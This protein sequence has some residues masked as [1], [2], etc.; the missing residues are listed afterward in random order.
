MIANRETLEASPRP[1]RYSPGERDLQIY[2]AVRVDARRQADVAAEFG[3][4]QGRIS[5]IIRRVNR[6]RAS[7]GSAGELERRDQ[8]TV[9]RWLD[10]QRIEKL[11]EHTMEHYRRSCQPR[12]R[13][14][15]VKNQ[16]GES[17]TET[18][19]HGPGNLQCLKFA[20]HLLELRFGFDQQTP[21]SEKALE[22][23]DRDTFFRRLADMRASAE[24][25]GDVPAG[26]GNGN[27]PA[28][29]AYRMLQE[30]IGYGAAR[31]AFAPEPPDDDWQDDEPAEP[32]ASPP[33]AAN[34][35]EIINVISAAAP[36]EEPAAAAEEVV[37]TACPAKTSDE[38]TAQPAIEVEP[39]P[40]A[41][42]SQVFVGSACRAEPEMPRDVDALVAD[43]DCPDEGHSWPVPTSGPPF[44]AG[45]EAQCA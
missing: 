15:I 14:R 18:I 20:G 1:S 24:E 12:W 6:W 39:S 3:I 35:P 31:G 37:L 13:E 7:R 26:E 29:V 4:T 10:D 16:H 33:A 34:A 36:A 19:D 43:I 5:Q 38:P 23:A 22:E 28:D 32:A 44:M 21:P 27:A 11:Y 17:R 30:L 40:G 42:N 45:T 9:N 25:Q 2:A 8:Q 41:N